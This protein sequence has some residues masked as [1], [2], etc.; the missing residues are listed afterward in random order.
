[1]NPEKIVKQIEHFEAEKLNIEQFKSS[2]KF[3]ERMY[4]V[5]KGNLEKT[6]YQFSNK[7]FM[8]KETIY[9]ASTNTGL[10]C[11]KAPDYILSEVHNVSIVTEEK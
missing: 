1:M 10:C 11:K 5:A 8:Y 4:S 9:W 3:A 7:E 6:L 2:L